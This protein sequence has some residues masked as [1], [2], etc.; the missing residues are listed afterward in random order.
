MFD[1]GAQESDYDLDDVMTPQKIR[2]T[3]MMQLKIL[4]ITVLDLWDGTLRF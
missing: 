3:I 2:M 4:A 1:E